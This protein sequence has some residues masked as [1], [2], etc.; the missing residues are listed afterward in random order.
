MNTTTTISAPAKAPRLSVIESCAKSFCEMLRRM[1]GGTV[2]IEWKKSRD[3]GNCP[4]AFDHRGQ[5]IARADGCLGVPPRKWGENPL[6]RARARG[7]C[8][9]PSLG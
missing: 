8:R 3:Y 1:D 4:V 2:N 5:K 7:R 9:G 6:P